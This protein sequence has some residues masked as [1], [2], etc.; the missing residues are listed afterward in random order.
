M[1]PGHLDGYAPV[2]A[3]PSC[4]WCRHPWV[5]HWSDDGCQAPTGPGETCGCREP[6]P[7]QPDPPAPTA[8]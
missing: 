6:P 2:V 4:D 8:A 7:D 5:A 1:T 3:L